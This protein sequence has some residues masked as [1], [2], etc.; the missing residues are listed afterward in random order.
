MRNE[1]WSD[2]SGVVTERAFPKQG[3]E[4]RI[5]RRSVGVEKGGPKRCLVGAVEYQR[6]KGSPVARRYGR[7][8]HRQCRAERLGYATAHFILAFGRSDGH[9]ARYRDLERDKNP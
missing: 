3:Q 7:I 9:P 2:R 4:L 1:S 6:R 5:G 8:A